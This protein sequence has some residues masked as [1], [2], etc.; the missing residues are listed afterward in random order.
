MT[1]V[2]GQSFLSE[3]L[4]SFC[5]Q[6]TG[7]IFQP[8][9]CF[10]STAVLFPRRFLTSL[11]THSIGFIGRGLSL[12]RPCEEPTTLPI[13]GVRKWGSALL[14]HQEVLSNGVESHAEERRGCD[15]S[16]IMFGVHKKKIAV[17]LWGPAQS[18]HQLQSIVTSTYS[19]VLLVCEIYDAT[20]IKRFVFLFKEIQHEKEDHPHPPSQTQSG[21]RENA[22]SRQ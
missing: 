13:P 10:W 11:C 21:L 16:R 4:V 19:P 7:N 17:F 14:L 2:E 6:Q 20:R 5:A 12:L 1:A 15:N 9:V 3:G 22:S 8:G 18:G